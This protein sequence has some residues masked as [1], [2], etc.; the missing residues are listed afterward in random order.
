M[1]ISVRIVAILLSG[2]ALAACGPLERDP[3][4]EP[5]EDLELG[6]ELYREHCEACH[7]GES[8]GSIDD[9]PPPHNEQGHTWHHGDCENLRMVMEGNR[10]VRQNMLI[11]QGVSEEDAVMPSFQGTLSEEEAMAVLNFIKT[12]WTDE[13]RAHQERATDDLC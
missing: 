3:D 7:G 13:Q 1:P 8:G 2:A 9:V 10:E 4:T 5:A 12:W 11:Q 6:Q